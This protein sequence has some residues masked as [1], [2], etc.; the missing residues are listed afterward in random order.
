MKLS[1]AK[2]IF[3]VL[4]SFTLFYCGKTTQYEAAGSFT[5]SEESITIDSLVELIPFKDALLGLRKEQP[6][7]LVLD[8]DFHVTH[9]FLNQGKG[10][11][12]ISIPMLSAAAYKDKL[13]VIDMEQRRVHVYD[14]AFELMDTINLN[15]TTPLNNIDM[16]DENNLIAHEISGSVTIPFSMYNIKDIT[17]K[18]LAFPLLETE[19]KA[20]TM[21]LNILDFDYDGGF[22]YAGYNYKNQL[23][24]FSVDN[25]TVVNTK[26]IPF[27]PDETVIVK[28][29]IAYGYQFWDSERKYIY[30]LKV[31]D[32]SVYIVAGDGKGK[33]REY[34][35]TGIWLVRFDTDLNYIEHHYIDKADQLYY[36]I[37]PD[38]VYGVDKAGTISAYTK[39][40]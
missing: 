10:P 3:M 11:G 16:I 27:L 14:D 8:K 33:K 13:Y 23:V 7:I 32:D 28:G 25:D 31:I 29:E 1:Y 4:L 18:N 9:K 24:K 30:D 35:A 37:D 17:E 12:E 21:Q 15:A 19:N 34:T 39:S 2:A 20:K 38:T 36:I 40:L 26:Q 5:K 22:I 6:F